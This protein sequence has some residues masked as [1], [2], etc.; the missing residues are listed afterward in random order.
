V[1]EVGQGI[2]DFRLLIDSIA[3][4]QLPIAFQ[5]TRRFPEALF[6]SSINNLKSRIF[7]AFPLVQF[8]SRV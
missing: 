2:E 3:E 6:Q 1:H 8:A 4:C 5:T 7:N